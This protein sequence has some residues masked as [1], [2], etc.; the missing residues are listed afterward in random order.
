MSGPWSRRW[1]AALVF[2]F[3]IQCA[4][5]GGA[6]SPD[7]QAAHDGGDRDAKTKTD[8]PPGPDA[9]A[10]RDGSIQHDAGPC[11][12][13][14]PPTSAYFVSPSGS[15]ANAG[16]EAAPWATLGHAQ[17]IVEN[18]PKTAPIN[19]VLRG[20]TYY[21]ATALSFGPKDSGTATSSITWQAYPCETP[22]VSGGVP[23]TGWKKSADAG[24]IVWTAT[25]PTA[26][27]F[28]A[29]Y[30]N[31]TR[32]LRSRVQSATSGVGFAMKSG[33]CA[34]VNPPASQTP[35]PASLAACNLGTFLRVANT[36]DPAATGCPSAPIDANDLSKGNKCLDRFVY[37]DGDPI[38]QWVNL[39]GTL[40]TGG[41]AAPCNSVPANPYPVGDIEVTDFNAWQVDVMRVGCVDMTQH[42]VYFTGS[43]F[44]GSGAAAGGPYHGPT[45]AHRYVVENA[46]D[47]FDAERAAGQTGVWFVDRSAHPWVISYVANAGESPSTDSVVVPQITSPMVAMTGLE[48]VTFRGITF[49]VDNFVPAASGFNTDDNGENQLPGALDC[50]GCANVDFDGVVVRKT[51]ASGIQIGASS[52]PAP[53]A[54]GGAACSL[55]AGDSGNSLAKPACVVV[56]NSAFYDIGDSGL[57][58]GHV[59]LG[60]DTDASVVQLVR[61]DN[62]IIQGYSR[63]YADGEGIAQGNGHD[64]LY[65]HNDIDDGYHAGISVCQ[66]GCP[67]SGGGDFNIA[68]TYNTIWNVMQGITSDGGAL[69]Y[70]TGGQAAAAVGNKIS[71][72]IVHDT[73]DAQII[74]KTG[75]GENVSGSGYGGHGIYLDSQTAGVDVEDN[76]VYRVSGSTM[77]QSEGPGVAGG[78]A[79]PANTV[80]NNVF[81]YGRQG[82]FSE[83]KPWP[84]GCPTT[85]SAVRIH[86]QNNL[87]YFDRKASPGDLGFYI[88]GGCAYSC[89]LPFDQFQDFTGNVYWGTGAAA[90]FSSTDKTEF[91]ADLTTSPSSAK[92]CQGPPDGGWAFMDFTEWQGQPTLGGTAVTMNEDDG[93]GI[94]DPAFGSP[95]DGGY[96][97]ASSPTPGFNASLTN[98][99]LA[100]LTGAGRS[101]PV[102]V[103]PTIPAT[104]PTYS[105]NPA[106]DF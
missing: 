22:V 10:K 61:V 25:T 38:A 18:V 33:A 89:G 1:S 97:L 96:T 36:V 11:V 79:L 83:G 6:E 30:Y 49:E 12:A 103:A 54:S 28:E 35:N 21:L 85:S 74:D 63:I 19:V 92:V 99:T 77:W 53:G 48:N 40:N 17:A 3:A 42:I 51:S 37:A 15:D 46:R 68:S 59:P 43:T 45:L 24:G 84:Q 62:N 67:S 88:V 86:L 27:P 98:A 7:A 72:N 4:G 26:I 65:T 102:I 13:T 14:P 70:N 41:G 29:L 101:K 90:G 31:G 76:V 56:E 47:A 66:E 78:A 105:F 81:A 52:A 5:H 60:S 91:H 64:I 39:N 87:F 57:H 16:T 50:E 2:T 75:P 100:P 20:G 8:G 106:T 95:A 34:A 44:A 71:H 80:A 104:F 73:T 82:M 32:R 93:G 58:I 69:Y 94:K 55:S 9:S 23:V